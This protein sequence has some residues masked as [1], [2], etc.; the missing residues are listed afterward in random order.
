LNDVIAKETDVAEVVAS[1]PLEC[2]ALGTGEALKHMDIYRK[3][4]R[5]Q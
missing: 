5:H 1:D 4:A 3:Q 2:V